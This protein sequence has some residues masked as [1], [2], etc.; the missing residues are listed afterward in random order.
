MYIYIY[1]FTV[2]G[3]YIYRHIY[4]CL[5]SVLHTATP[6]LIYI[7]L[8]RHQ[9]LTLPSHCITTPPPLRTYRQHVYIYIFIFPQELT[10]AVKDDICLSLDKDIYFEDNIDGE[11]AYCLLCKCN[12]SKVLGRYDKIFQYYFTVMILNQIQEPAKRRRHSK[13]VQVCCT[14]EL[15]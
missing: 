11:F 4:V 1:I 14:S 2:D 7:P 5:L 6:H 12:I 13:D 9:Q 10:T 15:V 8:Y 3:S